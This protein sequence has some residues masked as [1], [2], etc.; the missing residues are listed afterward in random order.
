VADN[1]GKHADSQRPSQPRRP[2]TPD[3]LLEFIAQGGFRRRLLAL[4]LLALAALALMAAVRGL[5]LQV[6]VTPLMYILWMLSV[7][8]DGIPQPLF[9][10][11]AVFLFVRIVYP[12]L[13][14]GR[15]TI[16]PP[17]I[18]EVGPPEGRVALWL[19]RLTLARAGHYSK[20]GVARNM[21]K[22]TI[23]IFSYQ[24]K[25]TLGQVR[26]RLQRGEYE[27][28]PEAIAYLQLGL[29]TQP[30]S[31]Q[32]RWASLRSWLGGRRNRKVQ[33]DTDLDLKC[34]LTFL[35]NEMEVVHDIE[36]H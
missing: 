7:L 23:D 1:V 21:A 32:S 17:E 3:S 24:G 20:R 31:A 27:L 12:S 25:I 14:T 35:E 6:L 28:P 22:L 34:L 36:D 8:V 10:F 9:W 26:A 11:L 5:A 19:R 4:L 15:R 18:A 30:P 29:V 13:F 16:H 33:P 2:L